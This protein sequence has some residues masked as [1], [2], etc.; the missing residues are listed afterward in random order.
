[1]LHESRVCDHRIF[2][3]AAARNASKGEGLL[4]SCRCLFSDEPVAYLPLSNTLLLFPRDILPG[5]H[6]SF[7]V[8]FL[9]T[10]DVR[11]DGRQ[12]YAF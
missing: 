9:P 7:F 1:M 11:S 6:G 12:V 3:R 8:R 5:R 2:L 4:S 10:F